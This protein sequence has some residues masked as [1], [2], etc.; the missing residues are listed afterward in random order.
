MIFIYLIKLKNDEKYIKYFKFNDLVNIAFQKSILVLVRFSYK[1]VQISSP[2][3]IK[4]K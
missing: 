1:I 4:N 3:Y 2:Y